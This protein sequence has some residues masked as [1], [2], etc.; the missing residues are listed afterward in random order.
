METGQ[1]HVLLG[2]DGVLENTEELDFEVFEPVP[3][4]NGPRHASE[5]RMDVGDRERERIERRHDDGRRMGHLWGR[6]NRGGGEGG[7]HDGR[8]EGDSRQRDDST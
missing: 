8:T 6:L 7:H 5:A 1:D 2:T 4:E 3:L